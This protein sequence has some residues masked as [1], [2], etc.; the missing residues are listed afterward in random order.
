MATYIKVNNTE[1][2][3]EI[4]GNPKDRSW[5]GRDTKTVTLTMSHD[6]AAALLPDNTPWS[7]VLRETVDVLDEQ[8][9]PT[10]ETKEV[11]NEYDNSAYS[12]AGDITDH[13]DGTVSIKMGKPTEAENA[14]GAVV[15]LTGEV[16]T[17]ARA[18]ELRPVIEQAITSLSDGE[19]A[20]SPEL[21][22]RWAD[23]I[24]ETVK[25]GDRRSDE[26]A[27]GVLR[28]YK[29]REGQGHT[30][31]ADWAP[32]LTP[33][34][35]VVVDVTHAGTQDDPIPAAR[36]MEYTYGLYY[37]DSED[38][39]TYKCERVGE[40]DGGKI[41]LQYLPHELVGNYFTAV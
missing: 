10:G 36:G 23:H 12:L 21:F 24:G 35:W 28:V 1:Y 8:D 6:E 16:V 3:A 20:K 22:P 32:H 25:P 4:N 41:V 39:K 13:R 2:P 19:A 17:M 33:A 26:D 37:L 11:V 29:V 9:Q 31:Q 34:L 30:T 18:A 38:G 15:A 7:I 27:D 40:A 5:G 14:V